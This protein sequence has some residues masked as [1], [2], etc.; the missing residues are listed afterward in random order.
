ML[1]TDRRSDKHSKQGEILHNIIPI[2][3]MTDKIKLIMYLTF[4]HIG[5][6]LTIFICQSVFAFSKPLV[7]IADSA[8]N[9]YVWLEK[10]LQSFS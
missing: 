7:P 8:T 3:E 5:K 4:S 6:Y 9:E 10:K 1:G 2:R